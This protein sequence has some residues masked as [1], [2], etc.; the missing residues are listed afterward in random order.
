MRDN[1]RCVVTGLVD[2]VS[3]LAM[4]PADLER[5]NLHQNPPFR[6]R[7][8]Y[9]HIFPPSINWFFNSDDPNRK[10]VSSFSI[11]NILLIL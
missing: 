11:Y 3:Y 7:T 5:Y 1:F 8:N 4:G 10:K 2:S 6:T 9:Y